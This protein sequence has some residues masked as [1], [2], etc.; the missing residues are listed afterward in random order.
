MQVVVGL[1]VPCRS[2]VCTLL[3][4]AQG[5][6]VLGPKHDTSSIDD[7]LI[8]FLDH[9][10]E[11]DLFL[12]LGCC[13]NLPH[14]CHKGVAWVDW[15][16]EATRDRLE[17]VGIRA[18]IG[19]ENRVGGVSIGAQAVQD[20][21]LEPDARR[22]LGVN[23]QWVVVTRKT[24][25]DGKVIICLVLIRRVRL[26]D[27]ILGWIKIFWLGTLRTSPTTISSHECRSL[28]R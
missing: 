7:N 17:C 18:A 28:H 9:H 6:L 10:L 11:D 25:K 20:G 15:S 5:S 24:V 27:S 19:L 13:W 16:R 1:F 4:L 26:L 2:S 3:Q 22:D 12:I 14:L 23:V 21:L 8:A